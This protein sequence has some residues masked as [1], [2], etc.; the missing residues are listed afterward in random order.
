MA[1]RHAAEHLDG[2][3]A[4]GRQ[5]GADR[6]P[7]QHQHR[8]RRQRPRRGRVQR[9]VQ[10]RALA[11]RV[12]GAE[13]GQPL[14][15]RRAPPRRISACPSTTSEAGVPGRALGVQGRPGRRP[16]AAG[17]R[18]RASQR[19]PRRGR[20][21]ARRRAG[22]CERRA[23]RLPAG[24]D[25]RSGPESG[26]HVSIVA[27]HRRGLADGG[28]ASARVGRHRPARWGRKRDTRGVG[29]RRRWRGGAEQPMT[30]NALNAVVTARIEVAPGLVILRVAPDGWD[31]PPFRPGQF[32]VLGLPAEAS[33]HPGR[34]P[35]RR[36]GTEAGRPDPAVVL[37]RLLLGG[38]RRTS[39]STS[40]WCARAR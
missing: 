15:A 37:D 3:G 25:P 2:G 30:A 22:S 26:R 8:Q 29:S 16:R 31:L 6:V 36:P 10:E 14:G 11:E 24:S 1:S 12:A 34:R 40:R 21:T 13:D 18:P 33:R 7:L 28:R 20:R 39:S 35:G 17:P 32:A 38:A 27:A 9:G 23:S 4:V 5:A 19:V